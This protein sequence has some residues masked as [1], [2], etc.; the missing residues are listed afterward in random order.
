MTEIKFKKSVFLKTLDTLTQN[1]ELESPVGEIATDKKNQKFSL[2]LKRVGGTPVAA[3]GSC[4]MKG[5]DIK[6]FFNIN[7]LRGQIEATSV[8]DQFVTLH[9]GAGMLMVA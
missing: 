1:F 8:D 6:I 9:A 4:E 3:F 7:Q 5:P 2:Q